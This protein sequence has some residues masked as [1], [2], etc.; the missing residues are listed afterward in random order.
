MEHAVVSREEWLAARRSLLERERAFD[1]Q[2]DEM[3]AA[4]RALP[5]VEVTKPYVFD[6][7]E[8]PVSLADLFGGRS[9][10]FIKHFMMGPG[11][12]QQCVGC[13][14]EVDHVAGIR[15]HL[16]NHDLA[17]AVVARAPIAEIMAFKRRMNWT[18]PWVSS[19][20]NDFNY[21][22]HVSFRADELSAGTAL[23][24][25]RAGN[26]GLEDLSGNSVFYRD[27]AGRVF[28]TYST[29]G[30]GGEQF[31]GAYAYLDV[32]PRGRA[33]T[34]PTGT[35]ADWVRPHDMYGQ[36]G[37]VEPTGRYHPASCG[38]ASHRP[39]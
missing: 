35:L 38:C 17:Y 27:G 37:T 24:N 14:F 34:G 39:G 13:S 16:E 7:P 32:S 10:L 25:Y 28:H 21:D 22:F 26:P 31:L 2:R 23:Y 15:V 30:R 20:A 33:E 3:S 18:F 1:R 4:R 19:F 6:G 11:Q 8:G 29:F 5:W 36:G 9:Q 12:E